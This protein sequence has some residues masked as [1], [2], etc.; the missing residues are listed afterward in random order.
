MVV[1]FRFPDVGEGIT[2]GRL[3]KWHVAEGDQIK[4]DQIVAEMETDKA[5]VEMPSPA[6][7]KVLK[8]NFLENEKVRVGEVLLVIGGEGEK[9]GD[10][11]QATAAVA[12]PKE[13]SLGGLL[14]RRRPSSTRAIP[15]VRMLAEE[16]GVDMES[17]PGTGPEGRVTEEDVLKAAAPKKKPLKIKSNFDFYGHIDHV[18]YTGMR[19]V[20]GRRMSESKFTAP[21]ATTMDD[22]DVTGL[23]KLRKRINSEK[24][25]HLTFIPYLIMTVV[26]ALKENPMLNAMLDPE[27]EDII[28]KKYYNIGIAVDTPNGLMVPVVKRVEQKKMKGIQ[29]E[30]EGL[31]ERAKDRSIDLADLKGGT[32][33]IS[34][35]GSIGGIYGVP[36]INFPEVAILG[37]GRIRDMPVVKDGKIAIRKVMGLSLSI[38]HRVVD[39]GNASRFLNRVIELLEDPKWLSDKV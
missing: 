10:T 8:L 12:P 11:V 5:V 29:K 28:V 36:V 37:V 33:T 14:G 2:E 4:E 30:I 1:E 18:P 6:S 24:D 7:G 39:G 25:I 38:D 3:K 22:A 23:Y 27:N 15:R 26:E 19:E 21:H 9:A 13:G 34:N 31:V 35:Y 32:F 20:I 17:I 16:K